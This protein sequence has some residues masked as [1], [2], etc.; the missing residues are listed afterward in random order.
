MPICADIYTSAERRDSRSS[1]SIGTTATRPGFA[2]RGRTDQYRASVATIMVCVSTIVRLPR[3]SVSRN[4]SRKLPF[5]AVPGGHH[6]EPLQVALAITPSD[7][8]N[9]MFVH[10]QD[11]RLDG[12][13][14]LP[15]ARRG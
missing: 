12:V 15:P 2:V 8:A 5:I 6:C 13:Q 9:F 3:R 11:L 10:L 14:I 1:I 7:M 4:V